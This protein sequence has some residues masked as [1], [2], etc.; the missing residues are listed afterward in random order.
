MSRLETQI[1]GRTSRSW[2]VK[3]RAYRVSG[4]AWLNQDVPSDYMKSALVAE[5][6]ASNHF[7]VAV[8]R[9]S[10]SGRSQSS[11]MSEWLHSATHHQI[12]SAMTCQ[13]S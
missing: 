6:S 8:Q 4:M 5:R 2:N 12:T 9:G 1:H 3:Q 13:E 7:M 11:V 10:L